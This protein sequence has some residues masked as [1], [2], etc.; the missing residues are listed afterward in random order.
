[1]NSFLSAAGILLPLGYLAASIAYG[2]AFFSGH[3]RADRLSS[4]L[5]RCVVLLHLA[6]VIALG[7]RSGQLPAASV[8]Q[9]LSLLAFS[10]AAVYLLVEH[11]GGHRSTG[12]WLVSVAFL[13]QLLAALL[14]SPEPVPLTLGNPY[15]AAHVALALVGYTAFAIAAAYGFLY[16]RLY[17]ELKLKRFSTFFG[18]LP[19]LVVLERMMTV[20]LTVGF[21]TLSAAVLFG[22]VW[23]QR[24]HGGGWWTDTKTLLT[25]GVWA[26]Y[27]LALL[28]RRLRQ[29]QG[30]QTA[31]ASLAGLAVILLTMLA[32]NLIYR[33]FHSFV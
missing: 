17:R 12:F 7:I 28:L 22:I 29:W 6:Q 33:S 8:A 18:R 13:F 9:A 16:L 30:H 1:M 14:K 31:Y 5:L 15:L 24:L 11:R 27:G 21:V 4:Y 20:A 23:A 2:L 25:L 19:P 26:F 32:V 10:V 3:E